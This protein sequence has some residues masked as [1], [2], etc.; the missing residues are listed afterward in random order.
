MWHQG[1]RL[2]A[3]GKKLMRFFGAVALVLLETA[4]AV[5]VAQTWFDPEAIHLNNRGVAQMSQQFTERA[6]ASFADAFQKDQKMEQAAINE[7]IALMALQKLEEAKK[8][9]QKAITLDPGSA[10]AWYILG[11]VQH[12]GNELEP[13]LA[14]FQNAAKFDPRDADSYYFEGV[15]YQE[16][17]Q[18]DKA[19]EVLH[20]T[21][22]LNPQHASAEFALARTLQRSGDIAG[23]QRALQDFPAPHKH[24][25]WFAHWSVLRRTGALLHR[26]AYR[27][28]GD[29]KKADDSGEA[30]G[31]AHDL[32]G[33]K[34]GA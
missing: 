6:A 29:G 4:A 24:Q 19:I 16:L 28:V 14:S 15:C 7:G 1:W 9:L 5:T 11:L 23:G 34:G 33:L 18:F 32:P 17:K 30:C 21:L 3:F 2:A 8:P 25:N 10:Q 20:K 26:V 31:A 12:A 27:R 13:A 22:E